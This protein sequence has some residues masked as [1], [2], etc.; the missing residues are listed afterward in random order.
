MAIG[1][2]SNCNRLSILGLPV[3]VCSDFLNEA[4]TLHRTGGG[5][6]VTLNA[7]MIMTAKANHN[8]EAAIREAKLI[9]PDGVGVVWALRSQGI[10]VPRIPG[11]ELAQSLLAHA[12]SNKWKVALIGSA[13]EVMEQLIKKLLEDLPNLHIA[14]AI[15]GYQSK[16]DWESLERSLQECLP[17]LVL[18]ALGT[19]TQELWSNRVCKVSSGLWIGVGGSFD[20]WAG[21]KNR[22]P[23]WMLRMHFEWLYRLVKEP[24]RWKRM[25][26][27]PAFVLAVMS[28]PK[29]HPN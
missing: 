17:D 1:R 2:P 6:I 25:L 15:H 10:T 11:I 13:P 24:K 18:V 29:H 7:E 9:V 3:D 14:T 12:E 23:K 20:I 19:P 16:Q 21:T 5:Q 22:A 8:L 27:L 26:S 28:Q 4:V